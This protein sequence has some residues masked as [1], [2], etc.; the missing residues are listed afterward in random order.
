MF[1]DTEDFQQYL[2]VTNAFTIESAQYAIN[3]A[4]RGFII[5]N[6]SQEE[7]NSLLADY[8]ANSLTDIRLQAWKY[9]Q[10]STANFAFGFNVT[11]GDIQVS[12]GAMS[13]I[14]TDT[15]KSLRKFD[16]L[17][18]KEEVVKAG[19]ELLDILLQYMEINKSE[20]PLWTA[21]PF[22]TIHIE[23]FLQT[24]EQFSKSVPIGNSRL[25]FIQIKP[26]LFENE[27]LYLVPLLGEELYL[28]LKNKLKNNSLSTIERIL[29][30]KINAYLSRMIMF[31]SIPYLNI[32]FKDGLIRYTAK[33]DDNTKQESQ[34]PDNHLDFL[35]RDLQ[36][37]AE[38][39]K[40]VL[41]E[42]LQKKFTDGEFANFQTSKFY[43]PPVPVIAPIVMNTKKDTTFF[44]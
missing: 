17:D 10:E 34:T 2:P 11:F 16:K 13:R 33:D 8:Q 4:I 35:L 7:Y 23:Y 14:E 21:S 24:T 22:Y 6:I 29:Q 19:L 41:I 1:K 40:T 37:Q 31:K 38:T 9:I 26:L 27:E 12:D 42:F 5:P 39:R 25:L 44:F 3:K 30:D 36:L 15:R 32:S 43:K 18:M 20:F 28:E